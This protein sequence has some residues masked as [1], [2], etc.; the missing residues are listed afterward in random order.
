M[1]IIP[2]YQSTAYNGPAIKLGAGVHAGDALGYASDNGYRV[3]TG[4]CGTVGISGGYSQG[5]GHGPLNSAYGLASDNVLEWEVVTGDGQHLVATPDKNSDLYWAL[6]GGGGGT[7]AVVLS[8]TTRVHPDG[9]VSS[10]ELGFSV[11]DVGNSTFWEAVG[12]FW[13]LLPTVIKGTNNSVQFNTWNNQ[14]GAVF[15]LVDQGTSTINKT[16]APFLAEF[17]KLGLTTF[18]STVQSENFLDYY[19]TYYGPLPYGLEPDSTILNSRIV[20]ESVVTDDAANAKLMSAFELITKDGDFEVACSASD[21]SNTQYSP[22]AVL[23][24]W[25]TSIA[26]CHIDGFWDFAAPIG[27]NY[28]LKSKL[29]DVYAPAFDEATPDSGV[30]LNEIDPWY[31]GDFKT[32]FY[33]SNYDKLLSIKHKHDPDHLFYG[34]HAVGSDE[35]TIDGDGRLCYQS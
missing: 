26:V 24:A 12:V 5:G 30:Y 6:A 19:A 15:T 23:P 3:V 20:P 25:R 27:Q 1:E 4:E 28:A 34:H 14:F 21:V 13:S 31:K 16:L 2:Q 33:G 8:M 35:F 9:V 17:N 7:Y 18:V 10:A 22:N 29:V 32:N 11:A